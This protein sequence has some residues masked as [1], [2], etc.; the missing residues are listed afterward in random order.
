MK[1][2]Q[3]ENITEIELFADLYVQSK[4]QVLDF[5]TLP[6]STINKFYKDHK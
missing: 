3:C 4:L 5:L 2:I 6:L 1:E